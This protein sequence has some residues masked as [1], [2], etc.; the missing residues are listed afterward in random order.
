MTGD[1]S[2]VTYIGVASCMIA[3]VDA[4]IVSTVSGGV[5]YG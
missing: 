1:G 2:G 4:G 5:S 3:G